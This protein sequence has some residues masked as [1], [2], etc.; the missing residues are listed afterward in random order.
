MMSK[1][2][3]KV[4][5]ERAREV[6]T[7]DVSSKEFYG[8]GYDDSDKRIPDMTIINKQLSWNP[9]TSLWDL[10]ESTLTY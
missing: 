5:R 2:Y 6:T 7:V 4:L 8:E 1:V 10:L 9:K 3:A